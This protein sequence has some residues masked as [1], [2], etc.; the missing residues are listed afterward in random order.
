[1]LGIGEAPAEG[2]VH[3]LAISARKRGL[4]LE[5]HERGPR[6]A[7][8]A[9]GDDDVG[10][11]GLDHAGRSIDRFESRGTQPVHG[12]TRH[13]LGQ[14]GDQG[15]YASDVSVIFA[16]LV[17]RAEIDVLDDRRIDFRPLYHPF[18]DEGSKIVRTHG[19]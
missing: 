16:G 7:F 2:G 15:R 12:P 9:A 3:C 13:C 5:H 19:T 1:M 17:G 10:H 14:P 6:H 4:G 8:N 18:D 11:A